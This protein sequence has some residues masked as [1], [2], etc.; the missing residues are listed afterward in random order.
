MVNEML[1]NAIKNK[2]FAIAIRI[3]NLYQFLR[4]AKN[5]F[6]LSNSC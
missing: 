3:V 1:E 6:I 5:E 2:S 4:E